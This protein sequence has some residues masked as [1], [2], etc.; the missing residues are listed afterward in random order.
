MGVFPAGRAWSG[1]RL[2]GLLV[3][4]WLIRTLGGWKGSEMGLRW[5]RRV[6]MFWECLV[7]YAVVMRTAWRVI[8]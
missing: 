2:E 1:F 4:H 7:V 3:L 5:R 6:W 8:A